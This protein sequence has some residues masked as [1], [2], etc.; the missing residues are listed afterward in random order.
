MGTK[1]TEEWL[2]EAD[3]RL[4]LFEKN[5]PRQIDPIA[6]S[7]SKLPFKALSYR[8]TLCPFHRRA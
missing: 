6:L 4:A 8:E 2:S 7:R 1:T 3:G 5:L